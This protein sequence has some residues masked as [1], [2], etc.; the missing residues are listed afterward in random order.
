MLCTNS[1]NYTSAA[2]AMQV[3]ESAENNLSLGMYK[4][5]KQIEG[6]LHY[7]PHYTIW[8]LAL[9]VNVQEVLSSKVSLCTTV[10]T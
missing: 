10:V 5:V 1:Y 4:L 6:R 7:K 2:L 8:F 3:G 9:V